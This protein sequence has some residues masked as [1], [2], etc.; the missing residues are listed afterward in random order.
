METN[1]N[2]FHGFGNLAME[3]F[4]KSFGNI[5]KEVYTN[6]ELGVAYKFFISHRFRL[7]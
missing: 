3:K 6:P 1:E 2:V 7:C 5:V 4:W